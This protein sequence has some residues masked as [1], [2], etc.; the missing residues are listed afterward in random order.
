MVL[1]YVDKHGSIKRAD[2][3]DLCRLNGP[4]AYR[5]LKKLTDKGLLKKTGEK[6]HAV[7]TR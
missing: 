3:M 7:Y 2:A 4:Q 1:N 6:K 5:L